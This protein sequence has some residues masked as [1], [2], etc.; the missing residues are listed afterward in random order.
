MS[1]MLRSRDSEDE[2]F[3]S[4][5][6]SIERDTPKKK[7]SRPAQSRAKPVPVEQEKKRR[8]SGDVFSSVKARQQVARKDSADADAVAPPLFPAPSTDLSAPLD[9]EVARDAFL[10]N[11][12][13]PSAPIFAPF[14][15]TPTEE[16]EPAKK[17]KKEKKPR[18][19]RKPLKLPF[20]FKPFQG[21]ILGLLFLGVIV[22]YVVLGAIVL[23]SLQESAAAE[24]APTLLSLETLT[25]ESSVANTPPVETPPPVTPSPQPS[26]T[27]TAIPMPAVVT[28]LDLQVTQDPS[29]VTL[30]TERG[31]EYLRLGAYMAAVGDLEYA[32]SLDAQEP[33]IYLGLGQAYFYTRRWQDAQ[34]A[35]EKV[36]AFDEG[37]EDAHFWLGM[38]AYYG[39]DYSASAEHFDAAAEINPE[40]PQNEAWLAL[41]LGQL[42]DIEE[43]TAAVTRTLTLDA[44]LP[45]AYVAR[46]QVR[47]LESDLEA[48]QGDLLHAQDLDSHDFE[49][50]LALARL[51]TDYLPE[52]MAEAERLTYQAQNWSRWELQ[53][54]R[55]FHALGRIYL[56]QGRKDEAREVLT[57]AV[58]LA[59]VDGRII[60]ATLKDDLARAMTP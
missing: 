43:A 10:P 34:A 48:A 58:D 33:R 15:I 18:A 17:A 45:L 14:D 38:M 60:L 31:F 24:P 28:R 40:N 35:L 50:L 21:V 46:A 11:F 42:G 22:V 26:P 13:E 23:R 37:S 30:R 44:K 53:D 3:E 52:R 57:Q 54:A 12:E 49:V 55:A 4:L 36:L 41:A 32:L 20:G 5:F 16:A 39:G 6:E 7:A 2:D 56:A 47:I 59:I 9:I 19:P 29:N 8:G 25:S 1:D 27:P 51:Y